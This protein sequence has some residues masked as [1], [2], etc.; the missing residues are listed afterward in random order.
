MKTTSGKRPH[1][2]VAPN[3]EFEQLY[4]ER[5]KH[6]EIDDQAVLSLLVRGHGDEY[7][8]FRL[9]V[10]I[11]DMQRRLGAAT[12]KTILLDA[13]LSRATR[14]MNSFMDT[15]NTFTCRNLRLIKNEKPIAIRDGFFT[16]TQSDDADWFLQEVTALDLDTM[17]KA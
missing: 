9:T 17:L 13:D 11:E 3:G 5:L 14:R 1:I 4:P 12:F 2:E 7:E 6:V 15:D 10:T 8:S 16:P